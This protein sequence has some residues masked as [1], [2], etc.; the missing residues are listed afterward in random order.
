MKADSMPPAR[1]TS[2]PRGKRL[3]RTM[4]AACL[5]PTL[6]AASVLI[7]ACG[8]DERAELAPGAAASQQQ[9]TPLAQGLTAEQNAPPPESIAIL[10]SPAR[11]IAQA[12]AAVSPAAQPLLPPV[13]HTVE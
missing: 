7:A 13:I 9:K 1:G 3:L 4:R 11:P 10:A 6:I 12:D 2:P 8:D 5:L